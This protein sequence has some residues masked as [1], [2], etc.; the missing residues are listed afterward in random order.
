MVAL[1]LL[2][3][4]GCAAVYVGPAVLERPL[5]HADWLEGN[6]LYRFDTHYLFFPSRVEFGEDP[7]YP[8]VSGWLD[9]ATLG[10]IRLLVPLTLGLAAISWLSRLLLR[11]PL[12]PAD[13]MHRYMALA[14]GA[15]LGM[16]RLADPVWRW[17]PGFA[18]VAFPWR[19]SLF[20]TLAAALLTATALADLWRH[21]SRRVAVAAGIG[22]V[23]LSLGMSLRIA[24]NTD[25]DTFTRAHSETPVV[26]LRIAGALMPRSNPTMRGFRHRP[27]AGP[28]VLTNNLGEGVG[29]VTPLEV[30]NQRRAYR[31][32]VPGSGAADLSFFQFDYPG[33]SVRIN[34]VP[35]PHNRRPPFGT[36]AVA[37]PPGEHTVVLS[38][39][40]TPARTMAGL[41]SGASVALLLA[42]TVLGRG[43]R[44]EHRRSA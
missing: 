33:W 24:G 8:D 19:L 4:A 31:V 38:F 35:T 28:A 21:G 44:M 1:A 5:V 41:V 20:L 29:E 2:L 16:T 30:G 11:R 26:R 36:L 40:N 27:P 7:I 32:T 18:S 3:G 14:L 10:Q 39:A 34:G 22:A 6:P 13:P 9:S 25:W 42:L 15:T 37:V 43:R 17:L 23:V 12:W